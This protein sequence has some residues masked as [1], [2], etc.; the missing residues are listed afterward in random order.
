M[1]KSN[2]IILFNQ[3]EVR[4]VWN[5]EKETWYFSIIDVIEILTDST[6]PKRYWSDLKD[7][8]R[9]EG[10]EVYDKIVRLKFVVITPKNAKVLQNKRQLSS[11][12]NKNLEGK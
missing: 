10:S 2:S 12:K 4:R 8:L 5:E 3:K 6:V 11:R 7:K 1:K 9:K